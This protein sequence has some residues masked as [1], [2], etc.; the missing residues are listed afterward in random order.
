VCAIQI[1]RPA[2]SPKDPAQPF[3]LSHGSVMQKAQ[4]L[5]L[6]DILKFASIGLNDDRYITAVARVG[7]A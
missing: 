5:L 6:G 1:L 4:I 2:G 7:R 3:D